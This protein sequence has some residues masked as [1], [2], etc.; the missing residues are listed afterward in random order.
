MTKIS[1]DV[2]T[3]MGLKCMFLKRSRLKSEIQNYMEKSEADDCLSHLHEEL[4]S[5]EAQM[6]C[7]INAHLHVQKRSPTKK[8]FL[9]S[10]TVCEY[11]Q[12]FHGLTKDLQ[13]FSKV[14]KYR[15]HQHSLS[16]QSEA[17]N[18]S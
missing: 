17:N 18:H 3:R 9:V 6:K 11:C 8:S 1:Q 13:K 4:A 7:I 12:Q 10:S 15:Q 5:L 14:H 16:L 2:Y